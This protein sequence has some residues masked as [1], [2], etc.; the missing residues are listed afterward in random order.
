[1][2]EFTYLCDEGFSAIAKLTMVKYTLPK[3]RNRWGED[4]LIKQ[5]ARRP[6]KCYQDARRDNGAGTSTT[7]ADL[8]TP[9]LAAKP[10]STMRASLLR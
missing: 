5:A 3:L 2:R 1:M 7:L 6:T 8:L 10:F 9:L 4:E